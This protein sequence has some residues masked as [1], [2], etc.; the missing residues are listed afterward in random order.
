MYTKGQDYLGQGPSRGWML[1]LAT[2]S[3]KWRRT[4]VAVMLLAVLG[5]VFFGGRVCSACC[6]SLD[7]AI[8]LGRGVPGLHA[9]LLDVVHSVCTKLGCSDEK[10]SFRHCGYCESARG[11]YVGRQYIPQR[12]V[13]AHTPNLSACVPY[14]RDLA[15]PVECQESTFVRALYSQFYSTNLLGITVL[16]I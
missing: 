15:A 9:N 5:S 3:E 6:H 4:K 16:V 7:C 8:D 2:R 1:R 10:L 12:L 14:S 13:R 11:L